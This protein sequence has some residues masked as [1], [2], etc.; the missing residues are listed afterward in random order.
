MQ[1]RQTSQ[2][3]WRK[4]TL[5]P[6]AWDFDSV[7][8]S[9]FGPPVIHFL[10]SKEDNHGSRDYANGTFGLRREAAR[11]KDA[12]ASRRMLALAQVFEGKSR[13]EAAES[14]GMD[15]Q[16]LRDWVHRHTT[17]LPPVIVF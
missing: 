9:H 10:R 15:R 8:D 6:T 17:R 12:R 7:G 3:S 2:I 5:I 4:K 1:V 13:T 16:T 14:C 11:V